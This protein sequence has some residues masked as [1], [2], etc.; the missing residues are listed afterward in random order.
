MYKLDLIDKKILHELDF[1]S[2]QPIS[3]IAKKLKLSRD[4]VT[5]RINRFFKDKLL[6]KPY[7][8]IDIS[9]L[10]YSA[11]KSFIRFQNITEAKEKE[12]LNYIKN[13]KNVVYSASYDGKFDVVVSIWSKNVE[14]LA[15]YIKELE[16]KFGSFIAERQLATIIKGEYCVR[17][18]LIDSK[19]YTKRQYF[20]GSVPHQEKI[21]EI[22]KK[23]LLQLGISSRISSVEIASTLN[24]SADAVSK[25]IKKLEKQG[26]IQNYNIVPN[27]LIYP[28]IHHKILIS[29]HNLTEQ[30]EKQLE[31]YCRQ[32]KNIWYFCKALGQHNF[33]IDI[34][35]ETRQQFR[36]FLRQFKLQF[37]R[38]IKDYTVLTVYR[39]NKYNFCPRV[40]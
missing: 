32:N 40:D 12:F 29:L 30:K 11:N 13:N 24:I 6:L 36:H 7:T 8:I 4:V 19:T 28:Y 33:E 16:K 34:D 20:F 9:K 25:R 35:T 14:Q 17:D 39:T 31:D 2:R 5:Y 10:G 38:I 18:Y 3:I 37:S 15:S 23:I 22:D 27:E 21:D 1:N 26:I